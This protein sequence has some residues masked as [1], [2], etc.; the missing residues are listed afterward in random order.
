[1][2]EAAATAVRGGSWLLE[3]IPAGNS[4]TRSG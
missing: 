4:F 2:A 1:M 3:D